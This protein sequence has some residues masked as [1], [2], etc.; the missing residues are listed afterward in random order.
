VKAAFI[1]FDRVTSLDFIGFYDPVTRLKSMD[2]MRDFAVDA[3][4][5]PLGS[6][7]MVLGAAGF[8]REKRA[9]THPG[10]L[11]ELEQYCPAV[12]RERVVDEGDTITAADGLPVQVERITV[13]KA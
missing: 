7:D 10:V 4:G 8:L 11:K 1:V 3:V 9:T 12:V 5:E 13:V 6:Y 2:I